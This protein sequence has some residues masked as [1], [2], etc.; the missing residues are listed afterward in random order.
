MQYLGNTEILKHHKTAFISSQ[1]C[2]ASAILKSYDWAKQQRK[3]GNCIVCSNHSTIEKDVFEILLRGKQPLILVLPRSMKSRWEPDIETALSENRL[4]IISPFPDG[5]A[6]R[7]TRETAAQKNKTI[8]Q[9]SDH[10]VVGYKTPGGQLDGLLE[11]AEFTN[12]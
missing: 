11:N 3:E 8:I 10:I 12:L 4:L 5:E 2:P 9:L 1:K 6:M 7:I